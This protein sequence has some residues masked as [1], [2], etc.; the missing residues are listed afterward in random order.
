ML[1]LIIYGVL[2]IIGAWFNNKVKKPPNNCFLIDWAY[3]AA[4]YI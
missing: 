4:Y 1:P 3:H 2:P